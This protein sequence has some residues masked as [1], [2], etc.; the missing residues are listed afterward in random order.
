MQDKPARP[1]TAL[2]KD[3]QAATESGKEEGSTACT[4]SEA[5]N[6]ARR[7][8]AEI[9]KGNKTDTSKLIHNFV[10]EYANQIFTDSEFTVESITGERLSKACTAAKN[11]AAG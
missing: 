11:S 7:A 5:D 9:F 3:Q 6:I 1:L 10:K 2:K 4:P 8:W